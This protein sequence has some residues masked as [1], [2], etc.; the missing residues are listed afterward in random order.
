MDHGAP[1][2]A[3][4]LFFIIQVR[5]R[6]IKTNERVSFFAQPNSLTPS[7]RKRIPFTTQK[8]RYT[9]SALFPNLRKKGR[10]WRDLMIG[11]LNV[12]AFSGTV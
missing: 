3:H 4:Q 5:K 2:T 10:D 7:T 1:A 11:V 9:T 8:Q 6:M 12:I